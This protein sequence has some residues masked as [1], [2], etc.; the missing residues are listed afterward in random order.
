MGS[1]VK[2]SSVW[3]GKREVKREK[4]KERSRENR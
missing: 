2:T 1:V 3:Q 4:E